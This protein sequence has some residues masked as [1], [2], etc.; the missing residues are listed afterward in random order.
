M[1]KMLRAA[2]ACALLA[3]WSSG[4]TG[5][6]KI[7]TP[8]S[9]GLWVESYPSTRI[10][11]NSSFFNGWFR[12]LETAITRGDNGLLQATI[13]VLNERSDCQVEYRYR[14]RDKNGIEVTSN[15][16]IWK[17]LACGS[18]EKVMMTGIA[19]SPA[20]EDFILDMRFVQKSTRF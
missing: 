17:T 11:V 2:L 19:P 12:V 18:R 1:K 13:A 20:V 16:A 8:S 3:G 7:Y 14:W 5:C 4:V 6:R 10:V 15:I 9:A